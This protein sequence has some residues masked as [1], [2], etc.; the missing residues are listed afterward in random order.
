[1]PSRSST[2]QPAKFVLL[3]LLALASTSAAAATEAE[4]NASWQ[5]AWVITRVEA[6]SDCGS[7]YTNNEVRGRLVSGKGSHRFDAGELGRVHKI[8]V[9]RKKIEVL[10]DVSVPLLAPRHEGPFTLLDEVDCKIEYQIA[11]RGKEQRDAESLDSLVASILE[12]H[13]N[14]AGALDSIT[15]NGRQRE[16]YPEDYER[17]VTAHRVWKVDQVNMTVGRKIEES[18]ERAS[19][20]VERIEEDPEYLAGFAAGVDEAR[21]DSLGED[22]DRL[23]SLS[24]STF[25]EKA[26]KGSSSEWREGFEEGQALVFHLELARRLHDCFLPLPL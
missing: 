10:L 16:P 23:L 19:R 22:C 1:M 25:V 20:L 11:L 12:R 8:N 13:D 6:N 5:G 24:P 21:R 14:R 9:K 3:L 2:H 4:L 7:N 15:W 17:T 18:V 26:A